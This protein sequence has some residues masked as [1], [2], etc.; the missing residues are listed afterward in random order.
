MSGPS[1]LCQAIGSAF[2]AEV[3]PHYRAC[4]P[5]NPTYVDPASGEQRPVSRPIFGP[6]GV[7]HETY[8]R[9]VEG[10]QMLARGAHGVVHALR[11]ALFAQALI[12]LYARASRPALSDAFGAVMAAAFHDSARQDEG[13]D[14]WERES[15]EKLAIYLRAMGASAARVAVLWRAVA[16]KD[17]AARGENFSTEEQRIVHDADCLDIVRTLDHPDEFRRDELCLNRFEGLDP[18]LLDQFVGDV[19]DV[20][21]ATEQFE[22]KAYLERRSKNPYEDFIRILAQIQWGQRC[23]PVLADLWNDV[24]AY[25]ERLEGDT[26][27][28]S[29]SQ[30]GEILFHGS[31]TPRLEVL[32]PH[33]RS[34]PGGVNAAW[35]A[36]VYASDLP[37]FAAAHSFPWGSEEGFKLLIGVEAQ[38]TMLVPHSERHRLQ[39]PAFLYAVPTHGFV[40][41]T[42]EHT[43][44]TYHSDKPV[45]VLSCVPF[46]SVEEAITH[47]GGIVRYLPS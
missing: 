11:V 8:L 38:V 31:L 40:L 33:K 47:H 9:G 10:G 39:Q 29:R 26:R 2:R 15:A 20:V 25:A 16:D 18:D 22:L 1:L 13:K 46:R 45:Q 5:P 27:T 36:L 37:A 21:S 34:I 19:A 35:P 14:L 6:N 23:W 17:P 28:R 41:T 44:H 4:Y 24:F 7:D 42:E 3:A 12:R 30:P 43:G 32:E